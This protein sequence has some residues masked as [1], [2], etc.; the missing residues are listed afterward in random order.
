MND[1]KDTSVLPLPE[2]FKQRNFVLFAISR[3]SSMTASQ[4]L[5]VAVGWML[6]LR[7]G[8]PFTLALVGLFRFLPFLLLF[9]WAG[10]VADAYSR[11]RIIGLSNLTQAIATGLIGAALLVPDGV[12]WPIFLLLAAH[13]AAQ[14]FLQPAQQST[15]P[16]IVPKQQWARAVAITSTIVRGAQLGG[17]ALAGVLI[18]MAD[19]M[20]FAVILALSVLA[21]ASAALIRAD[22]RSQPVA[23]SDRLAHLLAG[24]DHIRRTPVVFAAITIDLVAVLFGGIAGLLP[25]FALD[26]LGVGPEGLGMMRAMPA[27]GGLAMG[28]LLGSIAPPSRTGPLFFL[29]LGV[30]G[31]SIIVFSLSEVFWLSLVALA[32]Y[33]ATD[34]FSVYV[35]QTLVQLETPDSLR[36]RVNAVNSVSIN[37]SNEL[38]DFRAGSMAVL[39]GTVPAVALGGL[40]TLGAAALWWR[41]FPDLRRVTLG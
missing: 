22:L 26:V 33:G 19:G 40:V 1:D 5:T 7:T 35:R 24:M 10:V 32:I 12:L 28:L 2:L 4:M 29:A 23:V 15:L 6:Y 38:G 37:A 3:G 41:L 14:A 31:I 20:V 17:P 27:I 11:P 39:I 34:M 25:V 18:A 9:L 21:G 16:I 8:D 36:G 30:F 13:G